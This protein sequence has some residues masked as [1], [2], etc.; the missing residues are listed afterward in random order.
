L[1]LLPDLKF[2]RICI[3]KQSVHAELVFKEHGEGFLLP[4]EVNEDFLTSLLCKCIHE[5]L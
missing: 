5:F 1:L 3:T 4:W 2:V